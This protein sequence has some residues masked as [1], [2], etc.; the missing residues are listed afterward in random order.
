MEQGEKLTVFFVNS[1]LG[2]EIGYETSS[3][4]TASTTTHAALAGT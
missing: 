4:Q 2:R 3:R 1:L